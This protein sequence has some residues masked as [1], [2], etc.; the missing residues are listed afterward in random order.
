MHL[1][2]TSTYRL[3]TFPDV[4][5]RPP[6]AIL[7]HTW[8]PEQEIL[9]KHVQG[10]EWT[11]QYKALKG[12]FKLMRACEQAKT[13]GL[14]YVWVDSC[15]IDKDSSAELSEAINSMYPYYRDSVVCYAYLSDVSSS[16]EQDPRVTNSKFRSSKWFTRG[17]T[18]QE[19]IAPSKV[20]F[21][22]DMWTPIG[23]KSELRNVISEVTRIPTTLLRVH[24]P[25]AQPFK[26]SN[27]SIAQK[28]SWAAKRETT[29]PE[30]IAYCLM[31]VFN[32]NMPLLYGEGEHR[33]FL[34]LQEEIIKGS[35]DQS[36]FAWK[37]QKGS[38]EARGLFARTP[39][40]FMESGNIIG[41][42]IQNSYRITNYGLELRLPLLRF[43]TSKNNSLQSRTQ[44]RGGVLDC[45]DKDTPGRYLAIYL[46]HESGNH[47]VRVRPDLLF[48]QG[49][50]EYYFKGESYMQG[51]FVKEPPFFP[52]SCRNPPTPGIKFTFNDIH[53][54][55]HHPQSLHIS[56]KN[57]P[58]PSLL[59]PFK[60]DS[61][62]FFVMEVKTQIFNKTL[63][64]VIGVDTSDGSEDLWFDLI[65]D[66]EAEESLKEVFTSFEDGGQ[67]VDKR[68]KTIAMDYDEVTKVIT[69]TEN[70]TLAVYDTG[71]YSPLEGSR[72]LVNITS[73]L[74]E[75]GIV[76]SVHQ[77]S[78]PMQ[79]KHKFGQVLKIMK[80]IK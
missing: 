55:D 33:A 78:S 28:M 5:K 35:T 16:S 17:W 27:Y 37:A 51:I 77:E 69:Q 74:R 20:I 4:K 2:N 73:D 61:S 59:L 10:Q 48:D 72:Y 21:F 36:I 31:G 19:L 13:H 56:K 47:Y 22:S 49:V 45:F 40:E 63:F 58:T 66:A 24:Y 75:E 79:T 6:F 14:E 52:F 43:R 7:S 80:L 54:L 41:G 15:C 67:R 32:V 70:I 25:K 26:L 46:K 65:V 12:Y 18:L 44:F 62:N 76:K 34:R 39:S 11:T 23:T 8:Y 38:G 53:I 60:E 57:T 29:R 42:K 9:F 64:I 68:M 30:D 71:N 1:L 3:Q 50:N